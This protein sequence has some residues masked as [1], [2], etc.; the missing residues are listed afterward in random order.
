MEHDWPGLQIP[1]QNRERCAEKTIVILVIQLSRCR[2]IPFRQSGIMIVPGNTSTLEVSPNSDTWL[3]SPSG[4]KCQR[5]NPKRM[6]QEICARNRPLRTSITVRL[7]EIS[8]AVCFE[9]SHNVKRNADLARRPAQSAG[10]AF[11]FPV[12]SCA[13]PTGEALTSTTND[14]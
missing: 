11:Q 2:C 13:E 4:D 6:L 12:G 7:P 10:A 14:C 5:A 3:T 1:L 8:A 9:D